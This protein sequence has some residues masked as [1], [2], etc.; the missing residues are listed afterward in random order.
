[1]AQHNVTEGWST[2]GQPAGE[3]R[4]EATE[5]DGREIAVKEYKHAP[6]ARAADA[7]QQVM[8]CYDS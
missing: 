3:A 5:M 4:R 6:R 2:S 7:A 1:M 8:Q